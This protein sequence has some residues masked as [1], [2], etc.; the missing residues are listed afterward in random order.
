MS[1]SAYFD[2][3]AQDNLVNG[4]NLVANAVKTTLGPAGK[5]VVIARKDK[6]HTDVED[7]KVLLNVSAIIAIV[8]T[9]IAIIVM[10]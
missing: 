9:I 2:K 3:E 5:T 8:G 4:L 1:R 10:A 7:T 6:N